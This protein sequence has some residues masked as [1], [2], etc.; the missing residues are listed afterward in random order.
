MESLISFVENTASGGDRLRLHEAVRFSVR[1]W[2]RRLVATGADINAQDEHGFAPIHIACSR[3]STAI[4]IDLIHLDADINIVDYAG[5]TPLHIAC[6]FGASECVEALISNGADFNVVN[7]LGETPAHCACR[8]NTLDSLQCLMRRRAVAA[9]AKS[10]FGDTLLHTASANIECDVINILLASALLCTAILERNVVGDMPLHVACK[11]K[12]I[13][14][15]SGLLRAAAERATHSGQIV[16]VQSG[17]KEDDILN[18]TGASGR[19]PLHLAVRSGDLSL[20]R[21]LLK[22]GA[23]CETRDAYGRTALFEAVMMENFDIALMLLVFGSDP[24]TTDGSH[25]PAMHV[26]VSKENAKL[27]ALLIAFGGNINLPDAFGITALQ[28]IQQ[29]SNVFESTVF[30]LLKNID[31]WQR[32]WMRAYNREEKFSKRRTEK[33]A[34]EFSLKTLRYRTRPSAPMLFTDSPFRMGNQQ[35][36][37]TS[38]TRFYVDEGGLE[39]KVLAIARN[40]SLECV[41]VDVIGLHAISL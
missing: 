20:V 12:N 3:G 37:H 39:H 24:N 31:D 38:I 23:S 11:S 19:A 32:R 9:G 16:D 27:L 7:D 6:R 2:I 33:A 4:L 21:L 15:V 41:Y 18:I 28:S 25:M 14:A 40:N 22:E 1:P 13:V 5:N 29:S 35:R 8:S 30:N 26:C 17:L 10:R 34:L 36:G